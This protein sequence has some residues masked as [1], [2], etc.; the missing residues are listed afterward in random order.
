MADQLLPDRLDEVI[1]ALVARG[2]ASAALRDPELAPLARMAADL[3]HYPSRDFTAR[4]RARLERRT[5]MT[6]TMTSGP[7]EAGHSADYAVREGFTTV[8]PYIWVPDRGL[9]DFLVRTFDAIETSV[10]EIPGHGIHRE[11]RIGDSMVMIGESGRAEVPARP[12]ALH[13]FVTNVDTTFAK[14]IAA[15]GMSLGEPAD[16]PYG[17]RAGFIKDAYGNHW[18]IATPLGPESLGHHLRSVTPY[19]HSHDV[20]GYID[21][22]AR[23]FGAVEEVVHEHGGV[24]P[25]ARARIAD[26]AIEFGTADPM[27]G[28]YFLYVVDPDSVYEQALAAGAKSLSAPADRPSGDRIGFIEDPVGNHWYIARPA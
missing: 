21:F 27:P 12:V 26:A 22:L 7:A 10:G 15:G 19:L 11:L 3:R 18:Y 14:A 23:A 4:L 13:V 24:I 5:T 28:A 6:T 16:R 20:R 25:Y 8:T 2:D 17:E 1:D 9:A